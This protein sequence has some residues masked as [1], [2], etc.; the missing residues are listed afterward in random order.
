MGPRGVAYTLKVR[1]IVTLPGIEATTVDPKAALTTECQ[2]RG[3]TP[4]SSTYRDRT[5]NRCVIR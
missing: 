5:F 3:D 2:A 4:L 1:L